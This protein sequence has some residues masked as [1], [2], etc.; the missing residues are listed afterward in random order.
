MTAIRRTLMLALVLMFAATAALGQA[1]IPS[2]YIMGNSDALS[3]VARPD[4]LTNYLDRIFGSTQ[5]RSIYRGASSWTTYTLTS[6]ARTLLDDADAA[7]ARTTLGVGTGDSPQFT[8][9]NIGHASDTTL[10]RVSA[11]VVAIEGSNVLLAS[12]VGS[13]TQAWDADLD[14]FA[15]LSTSGL[16]NRTGAGTCAIVGLGTGVTT[17]LGVNVG[18]SGAF[19]VNGG[20]LGTPSSGTLTNATGLPVSTGLTGAGT[21]VLAALGVNVGSSGAFVV[22]GGALGTPSS[23][24]LTNAT[25]LPFAGLATNTM[26]SL[27]HKSSPATTD[28]LVLQDQAAGGAN[29]YC[30]L[31]E[32]IG[33]VASGVTSIA[34]NTGAFT[35]G[36]G[37]ANSVNDIRVSYAAASTT[38]KT[39]TCG[40]VGSFTGGDTI[41]Y[42]YWN[43]GKIVYFQGQVA[44]T[45]AG[46]TVSI[47]MPLPTGT[48]VTGATQSVHGHNNSTAKAVFGSIA[49][50]STSM[51]VFLYDGTFPSG[52]SGQTIVV[53]GFYEIN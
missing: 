16:I 23:G 6:F 35:L 19:V 31:A 41:S 7:T 5:D 44:P 52:A 39:A 30:T 15:A 2:G 33:A 42:R 47:V 50:A 53:E 38:T 40:G 29:K 8:A 13:I 3:R 22:N 37:L 14:C 49:A 12:G 1:Q 17:A 43:Y 26:G 10:T 18:S 9:V 28:L 4:S 11:G 21:G 51:N 20:A 48:S 25:G 45:Y 24:T 27:T 36:A 34:G 46:C 32:C